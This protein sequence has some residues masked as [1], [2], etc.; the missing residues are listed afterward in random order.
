MKWL[1]TL[2]VLFTSFTLFA[3]EHP[4]YATYADAEK[5]MLTHLWHYATGVANTDKPDI[6][7]S[8]K[9]DYEQS[10]VFLI[11]IVQG[12]ITQQKK[13]ISDVHWYTTVEDDR[14][15]VVYYFDTGDSQQPDILLG[16]MHAKF[17]TESGIIILSK[18][19]TKR[20]NKIR[21]KENL[22]NGIPRV[23]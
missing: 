21:K 19:K 10:R 11:S 4:K 9:D 12:V 17:I 3:Q 22:L 2:F 20:G 13:K 5:E 7:F 14:I 1:F 15:Q 6:H 18:V 16:V 8:T 23:Q